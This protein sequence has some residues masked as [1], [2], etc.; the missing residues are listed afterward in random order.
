MSELDLFY[1]PNAGYILELYDRFKQ[2]PQSVDPASR[3]VFE[4]WAKRNGDAP[5]LFGTAKDSAPTTEIEVAKIVGA[6]RLVRLVRELGH[7]AARLDPLGGEPPG[8][9]GLDPATHGLTLEDLEHL[10]ASVVAGPCAKG[11]A[12]ALEAWER[13]REVYCGYIGYE[14]DHIQIDRERQWL[15]DSVE[16]RRF[17]QPMSPEEKRELLERLT[18]VETFEQ[19]LQTTFVGKKRFSLEGA[20]ILV[21]MLDRVIEDAADQGTREVVMGMAHRGR[22]NV[23]AHILGK[24][25]STIIQGFLDPKVEA[26]PSEAGTSA[27]GYT[28]DVKYH[29][30][31]KRAYKDGREREMPI[32]LA[33][34]PSHLEFVNPVVTGRARAAQEQRNL[35]GRPIRDMKASLAVLIHGDGAFPGQGIVSETLNLSQLPGYRVGGTVHIILNNQIGFTTSPR[36]ARSTLYASDLAKGYEIPIVHVNADDVEACMATA[37]MAIAYREEFSKDFLI[38][39][40]GYRR[41]GH[42]ETDEPAYTQPRMYEIIRSHATVRRIWADRLVAEG[43][44]ATSAPAKMATEVKSQLAAAKSEAQQMV[45]F[46]HLELPAN[47]LVGVIPEETAVSLERLRVLNESLLSRPPGFTVDSKLERILERRRIALEDGGIDWGHA[48]SLAFASILQD[49][50][51]IRF[52]GQDTERGTFGHRHL[53]L[54]DPKTGRTFTPLQSLPQAHASFA[55]YNSP[56]S[57]NAVLG[58]EYGYSIHATEAL[59]LWE[60]QFGDF[61]NSAQVII[62][63]FIVAG[64]AKWNQTPSLVLLLPHGYEGMGPEHSSAR[65]ERFLQL[66][67]DDNVHVVNCTTSAQYFHVLRRQA[68]HLK[69]R[70]RP[71]IVM[72]PKSLLRE[73]RST[74]TGTDIS[75]GRFEPVLD[76]RS[77][78][79][80]ADRVTRVILCSGKVYVDLLK[81]EPPVTADRVA[82]V[83]VEELYP[84]PNDHLSRVLAGY[85]NTREVVWLQEEPMNM[86]AWTYIEPRLRDLIGKSAM[87][88]YVGRSPA[89]STA[90]GSE[91]MHVAEQAAIVAEALSA[92]PELQRSE[93]AHVR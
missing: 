70:P 11:A 14:D 91:S 66:C 89:A 87:L 21:P 25:Y 85:P 49:G 48:E 76:D 54:H 32:T 50:T 53:V 86:G 19:Y 38:D 55:V 63:Q 34:N 64:N 51:P 47:D 57:E 79:G 78:R 22:L 28:G 44:V 20:D 8:D 18:E 13:L 10:P 69:S 82:I 33:P 37:R 71:L 61:A 68:A 27:L 62:D 72:T 80:R 46:P 6:A 84:F 41:H 24:P 36:D 7:L 9:P 45:G 1:G 29:L 59:V 67:A 88:R 4:E 56:L 15:R 5:S 83:R 58:F 74:S 23:L 43:I 40:V 17:L 93:M 90:A 31:F 77:A 2:E 39:L 60:A 35:P 42:N 16:S 12:N 92:V 65:L 3:T 26:N 75:E 73:P 30:G 52:A 81:N